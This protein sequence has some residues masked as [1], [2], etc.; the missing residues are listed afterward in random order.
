EETGDVS[1]H[2]ATEGDEHGVA[3]SL[4]L[5]E[6]LKKALD[7]GEALVGL[8]GG[9]QQHD[10]LHVLGEGG[11]ELALPQL[12]DLRSSDDE[13]PGSRRTCEF[14]DAAGERWQKAAADDNVV[15]R[16]RRIYC[17]NWHSFMV[18]RSEAYPVRVSV[19]E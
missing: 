15:I 12:P 1:D 16:C 13:E 5:G 9:M 11:E 8:A 18:S 2:T 17:D 7:R 3:V 6:L 14:G 4:I 19:A 10:G